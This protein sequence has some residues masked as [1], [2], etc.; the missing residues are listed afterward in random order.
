MGC[1]SRT[2]S[3]GHHE[4]DLADVD[5]RVWGVGCRQIK[6]NQIEGMRHQKLGFVGRGDRH[7]RR[8]PLQL[9]RKSEINN[10]ANQT[11]TAGQI[12]DPTAGQIRDEPRTPPTAGQIREREFF[13]DSL[14][15]RIHFIIVMIRRTG[16]APWGFEFPF[17]GSLTS[18]F[19]GKPEI[20]NSPLNLPG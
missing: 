9:P 14:L 13:I 3:L 17:P 12:R 16:L 19:L 18:S 20:S 8:A 10:R 15:V 2:L 7:Q 6:S 5:L 11:S 1:Q 4:R